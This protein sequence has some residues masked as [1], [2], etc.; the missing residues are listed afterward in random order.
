[1]KCVKHFEDFGCFSRGSNSSFITLLPKFRDPLTLQ[2]FHPISLIGCVYK[3]IVKSSANRIRRVIGSMIG[4]M[5]M[6]FIEG[7]NILVRPM[8]TNEVYAWAKKCKSKAF[9]FKVDFDKVFNSIS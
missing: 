7:R 3:V 2:G 4:E 1:M 5:Q 6:A 8:I 9:F